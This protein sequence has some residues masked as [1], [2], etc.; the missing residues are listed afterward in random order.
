MGPDQ[1]SVVGSNPNN[2]GSRRCLKLISS[3]LIFRLLLFRVCPP[4]CI[5]SEAEGPGVRPVH[6]LSL[7]SRCPLFG[8]GSC[9]ERLPP[10]AVFALSVG[11]DPLL[12]CFLFAKPAGSRTKTPLKQRLSIVHFGKLPPMPL[13]TP[14]PS[15]KSLWLLLRLHF[16]LLDRGK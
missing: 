8:T 3:S 16:L 9:G 11:R 15:I 7:P 10:E 4:P 14:P 1:K 12:T 13:S 2:T 5:L 6:P